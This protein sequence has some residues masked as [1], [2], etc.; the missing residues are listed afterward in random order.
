VRI[1]PG[2][3]D[4]PLVRWTATLLLAFAFGL[5]VYFLVWA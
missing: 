5:L 1:L 4:S 2:P 3:I